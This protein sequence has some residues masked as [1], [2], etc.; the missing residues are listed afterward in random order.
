MASGFGQGFSKNNP[1]I[2][3]GFNFGF[4]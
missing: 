3:S 1:G 4:L 2:G